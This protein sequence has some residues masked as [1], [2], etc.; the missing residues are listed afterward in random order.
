VTARL[1]FVAGERGSRALAA[2]CMASAADAGMTAVLVDARQP[3]DAESAAGL[4]AAGRLLVELGSDGLSAEE[5]SALAGFGE[6]AA[7]ERARRAMPEADIV[8]VDAGDLARLRDI[9]RAPHSLVRL[10]DATLTPR[11]AMWRTPEDL[12]DDADIAR[13]PV[14]DALSRARADAARLARLLESSDTSARIV[15]GTEELDVQEARRHWALLSMLG[16]R[17]DGIAI[18]PYP[19]KKQA[20][21]RKE[22]D[23]VRARLARDVAPTAVWSG[24]PRIDACRPSPKGSTVAEGQA[25]AA[26]LRESTLVIDGFDV[27]IPLV[28]A[29]RSA[30]LVGVQGPDLV[31]GLDGC[32]RWVP[33]P[34]VLQRCRPADAVRTATGVTV[35]F[36][37]DPRVW[38]TDASTGDEPTGDEPTGDEPT[39]EDSHGGVL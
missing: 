4:A 21:A 26:V 37:P 14:F 12:V 39:G 15:V 36:G 3:A 10:L 33:L 9:V 8:V 28:G 7:L 17:V 38:P 31:V 18:H 32:L 5:W 24:G 27:Q 34:S 20:R 2:G 35:A 16:L 11:L 1:L 13:E 22:A 6:L 29:A 19:A 25:S 30:A 23:R